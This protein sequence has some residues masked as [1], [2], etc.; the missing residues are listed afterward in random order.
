MKGYFVAKNVRYKM[1][2]ATWGLKQGIQGSNN[3][4]TDEQ[5]EEYC[6]QEGIHCENKQHS[7]KKSIVALYASF[8]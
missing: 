2:N 1:K 8:L 6:Q 7:N 4:N 3:K 5:E